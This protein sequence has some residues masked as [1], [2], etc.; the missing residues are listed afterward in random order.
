MGVD[1]G[2]RAMGYGLIDLSGGQA[3][4]LHHG[5][6]RP[7][8]D[9][10]ADRIHH[11]YTALG[12]VITDQSPVAIAIEDL[13]QHRNVRSAIVL[14]YARAAAM[15]AGTNHG[16]QVFSY[17]PATVKKAVTGSGRAEKSQVAEMIRILLALEKPPP[18]DAADALAVAMCHGLR[19]GPQP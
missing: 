5:V 4:H 9:D 3:R 2:S 14:A 19:V 15:L 8:L 16:I 6:I 18:A 10:M 7:P 17:S 12:E 1:P 11:L 13:F